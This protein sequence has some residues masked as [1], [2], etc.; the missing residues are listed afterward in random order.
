MTATHA[1]RRE[2]PLARLARKYRKP[3][4][5]LIGRAYL[6][7]PPFAR[8]EH[9]EPPRGIARPEVLDAPAAE[10]QARWPRVT[11]DE[12]QQYIATLTMPAPGSLAETEPWGPWDRPDGLLMD[13]RDEY[14]PPARP[15]LPADEVPVP[16]LCA[17]LS[18]LP[19]FRDAL[20]RRTRCHAG[21]CLC[22][23]QVPGDTWGER[24]VRAGIHL[25]A[26]AA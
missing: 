15:Y 18:D 8:E 22:G 12:D 20:S 9:H 14:V 26:G 13:E 11:P 3:D 10:A 7:G 19:A 1:A 25:L 4:P 21:E 2:S 5:A 24:M 6:A 23:Q 17:D 16:D